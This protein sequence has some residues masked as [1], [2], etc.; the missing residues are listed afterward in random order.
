[1]A[2]PQAPSNRPTTARQPAGG[3]RDPYAHSKAVRVA[4]VALPAVAG[5][6]LLTIFIWPL[7]SGS[8][9]KSRPG[10]AQGDL[11][12]TQARYLGTDTGDQPFEIRAQ[13]AAQQ[14]GGR[15]TVDLSV[16]QADITLKRGT[17][18]SVAA[19]KG[20]YD[21][22]NQVLALDGTVSFFHG[23]GYELRTQEAVLDVKKGIAWG[24]RPVEG[25]GPMGTVEAGGFR[26][27]DDGDVL[28]FTGH[29]RLRAFSAGDKAGTKGNDKPKETAP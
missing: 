26:V 21:Q 13:R 2:T 10:P 9:D 16:P 22:D 15:S 3:G 8:S 25:Q 18:L 7:F 24:N 29:A 19:D 4:R 1:M 17:W 27:L 14:G 11:E 28:V 23:S 12:L 6:V 20:K 5:V